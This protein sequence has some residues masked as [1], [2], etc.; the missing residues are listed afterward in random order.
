[1]NLFCWV[2]GINTLRLE[3]VAVVLLLLCTYSDC[4]AT[5]NKSL[6][7]CGASVNFFV[8]TVATNLSIFPQFLI[9]HRPL[10]PFPHQSFR[11]NWLQ[12]P[13]A[14]RTHPKSTKTR[15][16]NFCLSSWN[17][18]LLQSESRLKLSKSPSLFKFFFFYCW[19]PLGDQIIL[20]RLS[21]LG[22]A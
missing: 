5:K 3:V 8:G 18:K 11:T 21:K 4:C 12:A 10:S 15:L 14:A 9:F 19:I 13:I 22:I 6:F 17:N 2:G 16:N 7:C 1:M 20:A